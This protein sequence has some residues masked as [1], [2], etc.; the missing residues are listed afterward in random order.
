MGAQALGVS[1]S[2]A[3]Q[4]LKSENAGQDAMKEAESG[5]YTR[6]KPN[7]ELLKEIQAKFPARHTE[8]LEALGSV[9][10]EEV[11]D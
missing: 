5:V 1:K 7:D 3:L 6:Y 4:T 8:F 11:L 10:A 2:D 9:P